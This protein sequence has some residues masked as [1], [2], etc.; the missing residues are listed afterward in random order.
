[1][2]YVINQTLSTGTPSSE[3]NT[4]TV[5]NERKKRIMLADTKDNAQQ[6]EGTNARPI[7]LHIPDDNNPIK[8]GSR[9]DGKPG[10]FHKLL[11]IVSF[12]RW[13]A[14]IGPR[15]F[16][17]LLAVGATGTLTTLWIVAKTLFNVLSMS[18]SHRK[19]TITMDKSTSKTDTT[20]DSSYEEVPNTLAS[21]PVT[22]NSNGE[23]TMDKSTSKIDS[24]IGTS[25]A[26][27]VT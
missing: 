20:I 17:P 13:T 3:S 2:D 15:Q 14:V 24:T 19:E 23:L 5:E 16:L 18:N 22:E 10:I 1:M 4:I 8:F 21:G 7:K 12:L 11:P 6:L 9:A 25:Y 26:W 27:A